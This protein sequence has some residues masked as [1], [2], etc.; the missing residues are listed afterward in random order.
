[1]PLTSVHS[2]VRSRR[3]EDRPKELLAAALDCFVEKGYA[4]TKVEEVATRAGV[5]KGTLFLYFSSKEEL[6]K[7]VV[8]VNIGQSIAQGDEVIEQFTG[9]CSDLLQK[10]M[11]EAAR[12]ILSSKAS[13]IS[14]LMMSEAGNFPALTAFYRAEVIDRAQKQL[15]T[16]LQMGM[17]RGEFRATPLNT[18]VQ[19]LMSAMVFTIMWKHAMVGCTPMAEPIDGES[20]VKH[21]VDLILQGLHA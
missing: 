9:S 5:S 7:E 15:A 13:G 11:L 3:K 19:S 21:H 4:A 6:F 10:L 14:K 1:M 12:R 8:R 2:P 18:T 20:F 17:D 16:V